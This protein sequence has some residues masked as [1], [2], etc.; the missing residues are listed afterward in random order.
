[1]HGDAILSSMSDKPTLDTKLE[2]VLDGEALARRLGVKKKRLVTSRS[3]NVIAGHVWMEVPIDRD[4]RAASR[5]V[6]KNGDLVVGEVRVFP[7]E[8]RRGR[9]PGRWSADVLGTRAPVPGA[10]LTA[11]LLHR[12]RLGE[13]LTHT[14][15]VLAF[16]V[17]EHG[18]DLFR[19][20]HSCPKIRAHPELGRSRV[21]SRPTVVVL[22]APLGPSSPKQAPR[23]TWRSS[24][25]RATTLP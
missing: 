3:G 1:M 20:G 19:P 17:R 12:V 23:G 11:R 6:V 18:K 10:G 9:A 16:I 24:A 14:Q 8:T 25:S 22:P 13:H 4:W 2:R 5:L 15:K 21:V 7:R